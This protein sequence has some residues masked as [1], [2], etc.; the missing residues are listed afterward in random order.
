MTLR[1]RL[2]E[3]TRPDQ[4]LSKYLG[5]GKKSRFVMPAILIA[6]LLLTACAEADEPAEA[7]ADT[8]TGDVATTQAAPTSTTSSQQQQPTATSQP[9]PTIASTSTPVSTSTP[10]TA[11]TQIPTSTAIAPTS[12]QQ[13]LSPTAT[14]ISVQPSA[15]PPTSPAATSTSI[16]PSPTATT[17]PV[18][19]TATTPPTPTVPVIN[20][21]LADEGSS[22]YASNCSGCHS[23][24]SERVVGPGHQNVYE[25]AKTRVPGLSAED[26]LTQSII[27][28]KAIV[29]P[30]FSPIM[31]SFSF[32]SNEQVI[33]LVEYL[34]TL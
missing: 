8:Q 10:T 27:D 7:T 16:P 32:F 14:A 6:V 20:Q 13:P 17:A 2:D 22:I 29:V 19:P 33:A 11:A 24:G 26:Y 23:K 9:T 5:F 12:T 1:L 25:T 30:G 31:P 15:V 28:S 21:Q 4:Y 3:S 34:K 18:E